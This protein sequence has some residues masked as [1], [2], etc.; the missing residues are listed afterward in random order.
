MSYLPHM[1]FEFFYEGFAL[2][3]KDAIHKNPFLL[4]HFGNLSV[5]SIVNGLHFH[6]GCLKTL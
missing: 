1:V 4:H 3:V 6:G 5:I 2:V